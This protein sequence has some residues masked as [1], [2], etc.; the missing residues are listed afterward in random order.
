MS[1]MGLVKERPLQSSTWVA[2]TLISSR[3]RICATMAKGSQ[4]QFIP[5][6]CPPRRSPARAG[7]ISHKAP[8]SDMFLKS[9]QTESNQIVLK[10]LQSTY[11]GRNVPAQT[12]CSRPCGFISKKAMEMTTCSNIGSRP[13]STCVGRQ[14]KSVLRVARLLVSSHRKLWKHTHLSC[15]GRSQHA[16]ATNPRAQTPCFRL[17]GLSGLYQRNEWKLAPLV[18]GL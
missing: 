16:R 2:H 14:S 6:M 12:P 18:A 7:A 1:T 4:H 15:R 5:C 17:A 10:R 11:P 3:S 8:N 13:W 9:I